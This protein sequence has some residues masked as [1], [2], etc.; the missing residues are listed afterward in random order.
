MFS[1]KKATTD[2]C[3]LI[4]DLASH[5]WENTYGNILDKEQLDFMFEMMYAPANIHKQMTVEHHQYFIIY[6][7][8]V[9][10]G[11]LSIEQED[12]DTYLF[13][14]VYSLPETHGT[15][16]G[17]YIIEQGIAYLRNLHPSPFTV[18]LFVNRENPAVGFYKHLGFEEIATRDYPI[19]NGYFMNDFIMALKIS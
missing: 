16:I 19:G 12:A 6:A 13:Q 4:H 9:P 14:K 2:D 10:S 8:E 15:G 18:K 11:Y 5:T 1:I 17:R 7:N 3:S